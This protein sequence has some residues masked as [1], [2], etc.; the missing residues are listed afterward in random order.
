MRAMV[1]IVPAGIDDKPTLLR[2]LQ[3]YIYEISG[4]TDQDIADDG[5]YAHRS[6]DNYCADLDL[7]P[8]LGPN[9]GHAL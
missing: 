5:S 6:F 2:L 8:S 9:H 4:F 1:E 7:H 3:L